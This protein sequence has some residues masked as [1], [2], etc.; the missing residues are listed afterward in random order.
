MS[1]VN[2]QFTLHQF[3]RIS[4]HKHCFEKWYTG[5]WSPEIF[6]IYKIMQTQPTTYFLKDYEGHEIKGCFYGYE[7]QIVGHPNLYL[8]ERI[9]RRKGKQIFVKWLGFDNSHNSW[10]TAK[11]MCR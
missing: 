2:S 6:Q 4:R 5:N 8:I 11:E 7:L 1:A 10:I 9:V 3:V